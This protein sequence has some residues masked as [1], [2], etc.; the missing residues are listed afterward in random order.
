MS[1]ILSDSMSIEKSQAASGSRRRAPLL[2]R[3]DRSA[4]ERLP[5]Q[6]R[7]VDLAVEDA[8]PALPADS[9]AAPIS[10]G[11][12]V[13]RDR[14]DRGRALGDDPRRIEREGVERILME[15]D[16]RRVAASN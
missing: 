12:V 14:L 16:A 2:H 7:V 5:V 3:G 8:R 11:D 6:P 4:A 13:G 9:Q 15:L 1:V 10:S